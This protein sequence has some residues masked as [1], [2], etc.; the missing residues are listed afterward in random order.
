MT[1]TPGAQ[2]H[3]FPLAGLE[4]SPN[5][6]VVVNLPARRVEVPPEYGVVRPVRDIQGR[7]QFLDLLRR[8][9]VVFDAH[10]GLGLMPHAHG[11]EPGLAVGQPHQALD[12]DHDVPFEFGAQ[13]DPEVLGQDVQGQDLRRPLVDAEDFGVAAGPAVPEPFPFQHGHVADL[14]F[15]GQEIGGRQPMQSAAH[16]DDVVAFGR[17]LKPPKTG[18][19]P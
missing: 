10:A 18:T 4:K 1:S 6:R 14:V 13:A 5:R 19:R 16:D 3:A 8:E 17:F 9:Q 2:V 11:I 15:P 7:D 12:P